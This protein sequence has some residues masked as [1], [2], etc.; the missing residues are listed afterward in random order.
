MTNHAH[1]GSPLGLRDYLEAAVSASSRGRTIIIVLVVTTVIVGIGTLD[2]LALGWAADRLEAS[3]TIDSKYVAEKLGTPPPTT[4]AD[5]ASYV[6]HYHQLYDALV[7]SYVDSALSV[8][9][10]LFGVTIDINDLGV[11]GGFA[12]LIELVMFNIAVRHESENLK[13]G[14]ARAKIDGAVPEFYD[15]LAMAQVLTI[16]ARYHNHRT[17]HIRAAVKVICFLPLVAMETFVAHDIYTDSTGVLLDSL[18]DN[19]LLITEVA[20]VLLILDLTLRARRLMSATDAIWD[21][22]A[23]IR[24]AETPQSTNP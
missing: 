23:N 10:P 18:H 14:F 1:S 24:F 8:R 19:I 13:I 12:L 5:Y 11:V 4:S 2:T 7:K 3:K 22:W 17:R 6:Q 15:L 9:A 16:P 20:F 21:E